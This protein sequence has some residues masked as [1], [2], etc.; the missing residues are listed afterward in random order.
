MDKTI[1]IAVVDDHPL[2]RDGLVNLLE[3]EKDFKVVLQTSNSFDTL[4]AL[5]TI[6]VDLITL[7]QTLQDS[8]GLELLKNL[9]IQY[10]EIPVLFITMHDEEYY[11]SRVKAAG[12]RGFVMKQ[13][14]PKIIIT[15]IRNI[16]TGQRFFTKNGNYIESDPVKLLTD[17]EFL[18]FDLISQGYSSKE[19]SEKLNL[20]V[21]TIET[22]K[23]NIKKKIDLSTTTDLLKYAI[24]W[25]KSLK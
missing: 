5:K 1:E 9:T 22:H 10:P 15:A 23:E 4:E 6:K 19:I 21:K 11:A 24:E 20:S 25:S 18:I 13:D 2:F 8:S 7:D 12:G 17:K 16:C 3:A 14:N